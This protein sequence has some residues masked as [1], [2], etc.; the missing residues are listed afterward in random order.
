MAIAIV[1]AWSLFALLCSFL[2]EIFSQMKGERGRFMK[3]YLLSQL[4]DLPNGINWGSMIYLQGNIT[5]LNRESSK[6]SSELP[7]EELAKAMI[8]VVYQLHAIQVHLSEEQANEHSIRS[9]QTRLNVL[10]QSDVIQFMQQAYQQAKWTVGEGL[11]SKNNSA[12]YQYLVLNLSK[13]FEIFDHRLTIWYK[14]KTRLRLFLLGVILATILN[15]DSIEIFKI[16]NST[17]TDR[18]S[19]LNIGFNQHIFSSAF[20]KNSTLETYALKILGIL[21]S[22]IVA[23]I[24]APFWF[25]LLKKIYQ[26]RD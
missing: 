8:S 9:F 2:H 5:L 19:I 18:Q 15:V 6:P 20:A 21:I 26:K 13:W 3:H 11:S 25:D 22:G 4:Q 14:K 16:F 12:L 23:S 17:S 1:I 7:A 10:K 24:G